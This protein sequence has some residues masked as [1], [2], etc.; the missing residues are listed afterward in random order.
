MTTKPNNITIK[1]Y[2]GPERNKGEERHEAE[3]SLVEKKKEI[4]GFVMQ[5]RDSS[6]KR[7]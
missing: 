2:N 3:G 6:G 7:M 1:G 4:C 5:M